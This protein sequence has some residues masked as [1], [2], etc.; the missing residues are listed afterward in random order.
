MLVTNTRVREASSLVG[1]SKKH[2]KKSKSKAETG[3]AFG[4]I[5]TVAVR[6]NGTLLTV[7]PKAINSEQPNPLQSNPSPYSYSSQDLR[8][9]Y[10]LINTRME[11]FLD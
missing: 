4:C 3:V 7:C 10:S 5:P 8:T 9:H 1:Q 2:G 11:Y 6:I